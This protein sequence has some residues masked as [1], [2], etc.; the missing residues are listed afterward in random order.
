MS[1]PTQAGKTSVLLAGVSTNT[2]S[3]NIDISGYNG[4][5]NLEVRETNGGTFTLAIQG[6]FDGSNFYNVGYQRIDG[7]TTLTRTASNL[8]V[9]ANLAAVYQILDP[10]PILKVTT[11]SAASSPVLTVKL[12]S[13][14]A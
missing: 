14:P 11:S 10:Y 2:N 4:A 12:Y 9:T 6:S 7:Q 3:G 13:I 8:S 5:L 1:A